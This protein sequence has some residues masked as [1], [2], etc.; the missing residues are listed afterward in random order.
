MSDYLLGTAWGMFISSI[1]WILVI[2]FVG[3]NSTFTD[4]Q[5]IESK[6]AQ[7]DPETGELELIK[8]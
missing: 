1:S 2:I 8:K 4:K 7:Y 3:K 6:V 5:L